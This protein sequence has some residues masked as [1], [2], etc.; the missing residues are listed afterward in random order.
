[1]SFPEDKAL[2]MALIISPKIEAKI[3][4]DDHGNITRAE[5]EQCFE[6]NCDG[7]CVEARPEHQPKGSGSET[8][9]FVG[10][11]NLRRRLKVVFVTEHG[12]VYLKSCFPANAEQERRYK[13]HRK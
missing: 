9:W 7:Y 8:T 1:M 13:Q 10:E 2:K 12:D 6:N 3:A 4:G 5:V 11:T